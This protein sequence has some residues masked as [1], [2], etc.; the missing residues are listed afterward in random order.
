MA[1]SAVG[2]VD[3]AIAPRLTLAGEAAYLPY[4]KFTGTDDHVLRSLLSPEDGEGTGVQLEAMLS[5]AVTDKLSLGIG[6]R[7]WSM[8]TTRGDV[9]FGGTGAIIPM[10]Y[11][12]EQAHFL[13]QGSYQFGA[14]P[15]P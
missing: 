1:R 6:G 2:G 4:V 8:W 12:A 3:M 11:A 14:R 13:V 5:Y 15:S 9:N 10:R 7:Y